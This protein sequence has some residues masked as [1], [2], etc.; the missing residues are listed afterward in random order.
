[1]VD[2]GAAVQRPDE[3]GE[4]GCGYVPASPRGCARVCAAH[5]R[6]IAGSTAKRSALDHSTA[7]ATPEHAD[8][9]LA[10]GAGGH[11]GRNVRHW[12]HRASR[13]ALAAIPGDLKPAS[14]M[15]TM[16]VVGSAGRRCCT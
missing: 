6:S 7:A 13:A 5:A 1:A 14:P 16:V 8:V 2:A 9:Q 12:I 3:P 11:P 15:T 4:P 10:S